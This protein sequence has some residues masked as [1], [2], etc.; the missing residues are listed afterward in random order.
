MSSPATM[1]QPHHPL[2]SPLQ[3]L[4][5]FKD[6]TTVT[7]TTSPPPDDNNNPLSTF[8]GDPIFSLF[9]SPT[10]SSTQFSSQALSS[11]TAASTAERLH[12]GIRLLDTQLRTQ[13]LTRH[14][15]LLSQLS[16][17]RHTSTALSVVRSSVT[18]LQSTLSH[19]RSEISVPRR[20]V[21][22]N[23]L[24]LRR[25]HSTAE[26]LQCTVRVLRLTRKLRGLM[27]DGEKESFTADLAKAAQ[28]HR[29]VVGMVAE[30]GLGGIE[31]VD[32]EMRWVADAGVRIRSEGIRVLERGLEG[33]N[34][35]EIGSGLQV[36]YN[37]GDLR[38]TIDGLVAKYK[39]VGIR[40]IAVALDMK[41]ISGGAGGGFGPGGIQRSGTP[42]LGAGGKA[43]DGLW[44]RMAVCMDDL[45]SVLVSV[46]HLQKVLSKKR[47]PFSHVLLLD[48]VI[49]EGDPMLTDRVWEAFVK[50]FAS[51]M[52]SAFNTSSFVK[53]IF[54]TGYP[55]LYSMVENLLERISRETD[56][57]GVLPAVSP[58]GKE[59][60]RG[61]IEIF[62]TAF[63]GHCLGRLSELVNIVFPVSSRGSVP[64]KEHISRIVLRIQEEIEAVQFD[65]HLTLLVLRVISKV[66]LLLAERAEYQIS[67][68]PE[69][70]QITGPA[71]AAQLKNFMLCQHLQDVHTRVSALVSG[72]SPQASEVLS[73]SLG[74]IYGVACDSVESLFQSMLDR[75]QACILQ[76]HTQNFGIVGMD[77]A[78]DN[79]ASS[80]MEELQKCILHFRAEF[81]S[82]L[83]PSSKNAAATSAESIPTKLAR[84]MASRVLMFFIRHASLVRPLSESGKLRMARDMAELELAVGQNLFPV[85]QLG[86]PYQALR[87]FR[88]VIFLDTSQLEAS[89]LLQ[90]LRPSTILHHLYSRGP[91]ELE[92]PMQRNKL[93]PLQYSLWLDSQGEDQI[94]K[95]IKATLDDY[96]ALVRSR[97]GHEFDP[98]YPIMLKIGSSISENSSAPQRT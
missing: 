71:T 46:W 27:G 15:D 78:M 33:F 59:Q 41:A 62:Q 52:K 20:T 13:V 6:P 30:G 73:P 19:L 57:K 43:K 14:P 4:P 91:D 3:K 29:E 53:E 77:S 26:L 50:S 7:T 49:Q 21:A 12:H 22:E 65:E 39:G 61:A 45:H 32:E 66:L 84:G 48:E 47:D 98:V 2:R 74:V 51:Q 87:A 10:F 11:G 16:S 97:S 8:A 90:D 44:H 76:I 70:R 95:G 55:K 88:P 94:W 1:Q 23:S 34:Q 69:A 96:E 38:G 64:S 67:T 68:G 93:T 85:E 35:A 63:L 60:M 9:L 31:V 82:R 25:L 40:S 80:Y 28:L 89:P 72:L 17:L 92:S 42:Q 86:G 83:L 58:D 79:N 81:L 56:V 18:S 75:L 37:L 5:T 36:F 54:T 24:H